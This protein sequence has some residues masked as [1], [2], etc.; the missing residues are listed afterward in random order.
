MY[1]HIN[2]VR[3]FLARRWL[4]DCTDTDSAVAFYAIVRFHRLHAS[5]PRYEAR[6]DGE[7]PNRMIQPDGACVIAIVLPTLLFS[8]SS[9]E[10]YSVGQHNCGLSPSRGDYAYRC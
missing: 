5:L 1:D 6:A 7:A 10:Q 2:I 8:E 4:P 9:H 3:T